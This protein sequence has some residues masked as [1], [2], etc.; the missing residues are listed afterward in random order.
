MR[1]LQELDPAA[2]EEL[3][4][5]KKIIAEEMIEA[6]GYEG[7]SSSSRHLYIRGKWTLAWGYCIDEGGVII[8]VALL[9][10][11]TH[12]SLRHKSGDPLW[13]LDSAVMG[14]RDL[15]YFEGWKG[16][17]GDHVKTEGAFAIIAGMAS[18]IRKEPL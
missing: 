9:V 8:I 7:D 16:V 17:E 15:Q 14:V 2:Y 10:D 5:I 18:F 1:D 4:R 11:G 6:T 13:I 3:A 12:Y